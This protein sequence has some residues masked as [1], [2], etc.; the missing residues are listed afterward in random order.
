[1]EVLPKPQQILVGSILQIYNLV[2]LVVCVL[3]FWLIS[4]EWTWLMFGLCFSGIISMVGC[5]LLPESPKFLLTKKKYD[6]ARSAINWI[7]K[8]NRKNI[9]FDKSFEGE[10][11][12]SFASKSDN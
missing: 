7:A 6:E 3:Y 10:I 12:E 5:F 1:M 11:V 8:F 2:V 4:K 9:T